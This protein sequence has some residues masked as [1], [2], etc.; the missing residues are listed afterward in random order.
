MNILVY[1]VA[2][3]E[4]GALTILNDF[5]LEIENHDDKDIK[6]FFLVST[7]QL[8]ASQNIEVLSFPWIK[9]S[10]LHRIWFEHMICPRLVHQLRV[11]LVFSLQNII[12]PNIDVPQ[13][14]YVHQPL[15]FVS[16]HF[17]FTENL[18]F[19]VYQN[20]IGKMIVHSIRKSKKVIVQTKWMKQACLKQA[21]V[22]DDK[23]VV[24][25]P[26]INIFSV[27]V[28]KDS[29]KNR[30][31]F[32]YPA[33]VYEYKNY[34]LILQACYILQSSGFDDYKVI[35]TLS[36]DENAYTK[37]LRKRTEDSKLNISFEGLLKREEVF[38]L[39]A[40]SVLLFP[41]FIETFG[42]PLLEAKTLGCI[43][44][45]ADMPF[46]QEILQGYP[47]V[48]FYDAKDA[49]A[50]AQDMIDCISGKLVYR[51]YKDDNAIEQNSSSMVEYI[52]KQCDS[53][54]AIK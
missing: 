37:Q 25:S 42:L 30:K 4:G 7:P 29:L 38:T 20:I 6:W 14:L 47:N 21:M 41:S 46:G 18:L 12:V 34:D 43:I 51:N 45:A 31:V 26:K 52:L 3:S 48:R 5:M 50:L 36:G 2:A 32:F 19:W 11:D 53:L 35:F 39:Y 1:D 10:W 16:Y 49:K 23:I 13:V 54:N 40:K 8:N 28:Y 33:G 27:N 15:P 17:K 22:A 9:K 24:I 44:L